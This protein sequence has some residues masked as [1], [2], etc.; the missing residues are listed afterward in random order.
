MPD[1]SSLFVF[2][3]TPCDEL[4]GAAE[5]G[6]VGREALAA[7]TMPSAARTTSKAVDNNS[8][9]RLFIILSFLS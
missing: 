1:G 5:S 4:E 8:Q 3:F 9:M 2:T 7:F 6:P